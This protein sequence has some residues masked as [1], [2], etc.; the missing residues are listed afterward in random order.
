ADAQLD[1][2]MRELDAAHKNPVVEQAKIETLRSA[3][4]GYYALAHRTSERMIAGETGDSIFTAVKSMTSQY[5]AVRRE[6]EA[7]AAADEAR[8]DEAFTSASRLELGTST[9]IGLVALGSVTFLWL[10]SL[11]T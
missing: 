3:I 10:L 4:R 7:N 8:I 2:A 9:V 11:F 5:S 6:L 1:S